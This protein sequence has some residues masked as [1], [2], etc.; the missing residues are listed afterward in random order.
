MVLM[1]LPDAS[2][3]LAPAHQHQLLHLAR[4]SIRQGLATGE[5]LGVDLASLPPELRVERATFVTLEKQGRLRGCIGCLQA[6]RPLAVD[7]AANAFAAA[8]RDSRFPSVV[9]AELQELEIHLS[10]LTPAEPIVFSSEA[11]LLAQLVPGR[12][13]V[14]LEEG[15]RRSTFLPTVW[16]S[17]PR[18]EE[19]LQHLKLKAGLPARH[20]SGS[21][22]AY[23]YRTELIQEP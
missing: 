7:V 6:Y 12:D 18:P 11:D 2:C 8:F 23:R 9:A 14:I 10:L 1:P 16:E 20:W 15:P 4:E 17:L 13:G 22:K 5:A 21:L 3:S 19:F